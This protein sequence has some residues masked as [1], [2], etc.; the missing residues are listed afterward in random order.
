MGIA[1]STV[2]FAML[3]GTPIDGGFLGHHR[4]LWHQAVVFCGA[5]FLSDTWRAI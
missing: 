1:F 3:I 4:F 2:A 5:R